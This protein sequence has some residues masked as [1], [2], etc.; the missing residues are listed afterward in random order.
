MPNKV[1][2]IEIFYWDTSDKKNWKKLF[3]FDNQ[4]IKII[5]DHRCVPE[6]FTFDGKVH[7]FS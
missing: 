1:K 7:L 3:S 4:Y 2:P 6:A 5:Y